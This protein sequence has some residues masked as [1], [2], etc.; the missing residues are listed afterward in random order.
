M[1]LVLKKKPNVTKWLTDY[2]GIPLVL[3]LTLYFQALRFAK[4]CNKPSSRNPPY[5]DRES[6]TFPTIMEETKKI[7]KIGIIIDDGAAA[8]AKPYHRVRALK[9]LFWSFLSIFC[10]SCF[11]RLANFLLHIWQMGLLANFVIETLYLRN[12]FAQ[13]CSFFALVYDLQKVRF[14]SWHL[15]RSIE[16]KLG[17]TNSRKKG[18]TFSSQIS[19]SS[20]LLLSNPGNRPRGE[21]QN[22]QH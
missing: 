20:A 13:L 2:R 14:S 3:T 22:Q 6:V 12:I 10:Y 5:W 19:S 11:C 1:R 16:I 18:S 21:I 9:I 4:D 7:C 8:A 17:Q 15:P